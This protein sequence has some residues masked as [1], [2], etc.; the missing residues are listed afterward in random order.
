MATTIRVELGAR[1]YEVR[2]GSFGADE[3]A[4]A[5]A[6][7]LPQGTT[8][9]AVLVDAGLGACSPRVGPIVEA[10]GRRLP[11]VE[12]LDLPAGEASKNL[13]EIERTT[14]WLASREYD[15]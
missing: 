15:R 12:R 6:E 3:V 11:R 2:I 7:A 14:E 13:G 8:G 9:V 4:G 10:L 5:I 1:S